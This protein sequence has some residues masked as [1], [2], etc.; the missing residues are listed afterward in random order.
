MPSL[1]YTKHGRVVYMFIVVLFCWH[2]NA[3][4]LVEHGEFVKQLGLGSSYLLHFG[5]DGPNVNLFFE[6]KLTQQL[7]EIGHFIP[8]ISFL[9]PSECYSRAQ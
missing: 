2:C 6:N 4:S 5:M 8:E 3:D 1:W 9:F 7:S